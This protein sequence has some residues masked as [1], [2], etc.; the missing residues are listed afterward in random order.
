MSPHL[1]SNKSSIAPSRALAPLKGRQCRAR[2]PPL[3]TAMHTRSPKPTPEAYLST[4][5]RHHVDTNHFGAT[6]YSGRF[7]PFPQAAPISL[8]SPSGAASR[9][10]PSTSSASFLA[11]TAPNL[12]PTVDLGAVKGWGPA[13]HN[14]RTRQGEEGLPWR[15]GKFK[16]KSERGSSKSQSAPN[17]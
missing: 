7:R 2:I 3:Q 15:G 9:A 10:T 13:P 1:A 6:V 4:L 5:S 16:G 11:L 17:S 12:G 14:G 8:L